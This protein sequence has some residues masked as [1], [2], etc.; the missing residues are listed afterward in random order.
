[1]GLEFFLDNFSV[2]KTIFSTSI[3]GI[4]I[5]DS[6]G[7]ITECNK[8]YAEIFGYSNS[9]ELIGINYNELF[10]KNLNCNPC[11]EFETTGIKKDKTLITIIVK[12]ICINENNQKYQIIF[13]TDIT[14]EKKANR[15]KSDFLANMSHEI[16][17]PLNA[18]MGFS[19]LLK[20]YKEING[21]S[22]L[23]EIVDVLNISSRQLLDVVNN[24]LNVAKIERGNIE[25]NSDVMSIDTIVDNISNNFQKIIQQKGLQF[26]V[27][28]ANN[29][30]NQLYGDIFKVEEIIKNILSNAIKF[31]EKGKIELRINTA[32]YE[33]EKIFLKFEVEDTGIGIEPEN[34]EK[35]FD[36]FVQI[37]HYLN[38][39]YQGSGLGLSLAKKLIEILNGTI[40]VKSEKGKG[41]LFIFEL[42]FKSGTTDFTNTLSEIESVNPMNKKRILIAEDNEVN[43]IL[44]KNMLRNENHLFD[45]VED[46]KTAVEKAVLEKYDLI[47]MDIQ[48]PVMNGMEATAE[49]KKYKND[50]PIIAITAFALDYDKKVITEAGINDYLSKPFTKHQLIDAINKNIK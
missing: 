25:V 19:S 8:K 30:P 27:K 33:N 2:Y 15:A 31:T 4:I 49:I 20:E 13:A 23:M 48:M 9:Y 24:I 6:K 41:S 43:I 37:E 50:I 45:Y 16:R 12:Q 10:V 26:N 21:N 38:K 18:V 5:A 29:I 46:G 42:P 22:E 40:T 17:T 3:N 7:I 11:E 47:L 36:D 1:L 32:K 34:L 28:I 35:I 39:K 14:K 44:L